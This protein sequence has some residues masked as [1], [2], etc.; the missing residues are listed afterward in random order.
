MVSA[1]N[2]GVIV[3][4]AFKCFERLYFLDFFLLRILT[5]PH[6]EVTM[7]GLPGSDRIKLVVLWRFGF[8]LKV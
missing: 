8:S 7:K 1:L 3:F 4:E 6:V 5:G 2:Q